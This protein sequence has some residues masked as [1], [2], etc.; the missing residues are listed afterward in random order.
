MNT[1]SSTAATG[2][3]PASGLLAV[4]LLA[5]LPLAGADAIAQ[6]GGTPAESPSGP[7]LLVAPSRFD[8]LVPEA[9]RDAQAR[10]VNLY[11]RADNDSMRGSRLP[12]GL[13]AD[14]GEAIAEAWR[15]LAGDV[16]GVFALRDSIHAQQDHPLGNE[17]YAT[18]LPPSWITVAAA[19]AARG[20]APTRPTTPGLLD[21]ASWAAL[22]QE[23]LFGSFPADALLFDRAGDA[24]TGRSESER[25][26]VLNARRTLRQLG[27]Q[28]SALVDAAAAGPEAVAQRGA[29]LVSEGDRRYFGE[30]L[31]RER[32]VL[33]GLE[34]P[35]DAERALGAGFV[36][37]DDAVAAPLSDE[38]VTLVRDTVLRRR[39]VDGE[40]GLGTYDLADPEVRA[41]LIAVLRGLIPRGDPVDTGFVWIVF[42]GAAGP[43][44]RRGAALE[45][46]ATFK[47]EARAA[48][49]NTGRMD[50]LPAEALAPPDA[51][52]GAELLEGALSAH[53]AARVLLP[54]TLDGA[55]TRAL[56]EAM[57]GS[58]VALAPVVLDGPAE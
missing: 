54:L 15:R 27:Q 16:R 45:A 48:L 58:P 3:R 42:E 47:R 17:P 21:D 10:F 41:H 36:P 31:R 43:D 52:L 19:A 40:I 14:D 44:G 51:A 9:D 34:S 57:S 29:E 12:T 11:Y 13:W 53:D 23:H 1:R 39:M 28:A 26:R 20:E 55:A 30:A 7:R 4:A 37:A 8:R 35:S 18:A 38:L 6:T 25:R 2:I 56:I 49:V 33:I 50:F 5:M 32:L 22:T 46:V 24:T